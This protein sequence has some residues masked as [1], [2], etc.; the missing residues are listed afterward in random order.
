MSLSVIECNEETCKHNE[1]GYCEAS[2][3]EI[4]NQE[5]MTYTYEGGYE[6]DDE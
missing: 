3:V 5:C 2:W 4:I 1:D 6:E